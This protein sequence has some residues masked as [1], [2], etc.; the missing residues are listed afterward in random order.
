MA[1]VLNGRDGLRAASQVLLDTCHQHT[2][3]FPGHKQE[4]L[5]TAGSSTQWSW[6]LHYSQNIIQI[7]SPLTLTP[8]SYPK[9]LFWGAVLGL[10]CCRRVFSSRCEL[11]C[12]GFSCGSL[13][14]CTAGALERLGSVVTAHRLEWL[15]HMG[16]VV[17]WHVRSSGSETEPMSPVSIGGF[18][19][20][21]PPGKPS[22][23]ILY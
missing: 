1:D 4:C 6:Q 22:S 18:C 20:T 14:C 3:L 17:P 23:L 10:C 12:S 8:D 2:C 11:Q 13:S 21:A 16:L 9:N 19:T 15:W 7:K 5:C